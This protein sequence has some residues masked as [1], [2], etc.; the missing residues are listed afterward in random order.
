M[1][2]YTFD[3]THRVKYYDTDKMGY[4][5]NSNYFRYF[6]IGREETM[7]SL[8][9]SYDSLEKSGVM[10]PLIEQHARYHIPAVYDDTVIIRTHIRTVPSAK[11]H[12]DYEVLRKQ[13]DK[14]ILLCEG[15]NDLC[16]V[17]CQTRKPL[18][19]PSEIKDKLKALLS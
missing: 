16:F 14:E 3:F 11:I 17:D 13:G 19:C 9:I 1:K 8:G 18:R 5:H 7:R 15:W 4:V 12:F 10:M 6:E 2:E